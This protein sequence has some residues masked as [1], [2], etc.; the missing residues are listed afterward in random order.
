MAELW[1]CAMEISKCY[2]LPDGIVPDLPT[3][4][5]T[6][7]APFNNAM[8]FGSSEFYKNKTKLSKYLFHYP[9]KQS[10]EEK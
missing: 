8:Y 6:N 7:S 9:R 3:V 5:E 1:L 2:F 10:D 4:G